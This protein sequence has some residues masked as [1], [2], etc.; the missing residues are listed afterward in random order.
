MSYDVNQRAGDI[1]SRLMAK[2]DRKFIRVT[3]IYGDKKA[4]NETFEALK[5]MLGLM[6][7]K[8]QNPPKTYKIR[9]L[10]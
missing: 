10:P 7:H 4:R 2:Q 1:F 9:L 8:Y 3:A 5:N 6:G